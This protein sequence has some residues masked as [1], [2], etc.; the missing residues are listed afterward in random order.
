MSRDRNNYIFSSVAAAVPAV[1]APRV[2]AAV[3]QAGR[4]AEAVARGRYIA[5]KLFLE[6]N[7]QTPVFA[8]GVSL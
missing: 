7:L 6:N 5:N 4:A 2:T 3:A 8:T 1:A